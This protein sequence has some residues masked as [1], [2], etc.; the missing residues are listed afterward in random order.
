MTVNYTYIRAIG[1]GY[2]NVGC[3]V[4]GTSNLYEDIVWDKGDPIP[5]KAELDAW[6]EAQVKA[7]M[8]KKIQAERD[9][10][11]AGGVK[12]GTDWFHSD[13]PSRI[14]QLGLVMMGANMPNNIM[15]KTM[16]G[17][18]VQMTPTLAAQIFQATAA[19]DMNIFAVAEQK[20]AA[21]LAST[22]PAT[23][24]YL[25]GWPLIYGE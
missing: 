23:Y 2:P 14:Q 21:M 8:W 16:T 17:S 24:D 10:R 11:K 9:R 5:P 1:D 18:F 3:H 19:N 6:I 22:D 12:V 7:D 20:R 15:W 4:V 13:D 25:S